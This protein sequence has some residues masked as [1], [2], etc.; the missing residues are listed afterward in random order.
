MSCQRAV[1]RR[2]SSSGL[3]VAGLAGI[4]RHRCVQHRL[5]RIERDEAGAEGDALRASARELVHDG[6]VDEIRAKI[7]LHRRRA[8]AERASVH[9]EPAAIVDRR[10]EARTSACASA[11]HSRSP[12]AAHLAGVQSASAQSF[13]GSPVRQNHSTRV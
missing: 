13:A 12:A 7:A 11:A 8:T 9:R 4:E 3:D 6:R 10:R 2:A 5:G 1:E